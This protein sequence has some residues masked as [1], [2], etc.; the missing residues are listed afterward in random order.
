[1]NQALLARMPW[2][3]STKQEPSTPL[4]PSGRADRGGSIRLRIAACA[5]ADLKAHESGPFAGCFGPGVDA[6]VWS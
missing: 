5:R 3:T 1:M 4:S 6:P 2:A